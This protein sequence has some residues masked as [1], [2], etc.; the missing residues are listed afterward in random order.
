M[1]QL[2]LIT[3]FR[4]TSRLTSGTTWHSAAMVFSARGDA[5]DAALTKYTKHL[6][7]DVLEKETGVSPGF[8]SHGG[9]SVTRDPQRLKE[10]QYVT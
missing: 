5:H 3:L 4:I 6:A 9:L 1:C 7:T 8:I 10:F 2:Q